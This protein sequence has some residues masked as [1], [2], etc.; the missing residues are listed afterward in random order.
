MSYVSVPIVG[1]WL[2]SS[3]GCIRSVIQRYCVSIV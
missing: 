1:E 2:D 3:M